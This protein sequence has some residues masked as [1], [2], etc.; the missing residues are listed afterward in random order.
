MPDRTGR[1]TRALVTSDTHSN[2]AA[3]DHCVI[4]CGNEIGADRR[5]V[6]RI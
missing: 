4:G 3:S 1:S 6:V 5:N 2:R